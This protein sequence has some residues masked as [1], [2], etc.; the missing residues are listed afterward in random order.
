MCDRTSNNFQV[1]FDEDYC[2][3]S[4]HSLFAKKPWDY[5]RPP[6]ESFYILRSIDQKGLSSPFYLPESTQYDSILCAHVADVD[7]DAKKEVLIG[8]YGRQLLIYKECKN[9]IIYH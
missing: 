5:C 3:V 1:W 7:W 2:I 8:S 9:N 4:Y 6:N